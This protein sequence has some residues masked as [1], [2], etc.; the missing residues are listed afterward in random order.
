MIQ[1]K[2]VVTA[3]A[4]AAV[5]LTL[6]I[7]PGAIATADPEHR[8]S[9]SGHSDRRDD[10]GRRGDD[11]FRAGTS[12]NDSRGDIAGRTEQSAARTG[13][14]EQS[15]ARAGSSAAADAARSSEDSSSGAT[16]RPSVTTADGARTV[17]T[18]RTARTADDIS[19]GS[20]LRPAAPVAPSQPSAPELTPS[21]GVAESAPPP[22]SPATPVDTPADVI[23]PLATAPV[24]A[25]IAPP[26]A[27]LRVADV[28]LS[29]LPI[30]PDPRPGQPM[31][32]LFGILGLLLI[33]LAG[34]ALG[35]RQA[36]AARSV[37]ALP[38][39]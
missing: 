6:V 14:T 29:A 26:V 20:G 5:A 3:V 16:S 31:T 21:A 38:R 35:Y 27:G 12:S 2:R 33:P 39:I 13:S 23:A 24:A 18:A 15:A 10:S 7:A 37:G 28:S 30:G 17:R 36:R 19:T 32:S 25:P 1:W 9:H 4:G 34:A 11:G 22:R 8:G